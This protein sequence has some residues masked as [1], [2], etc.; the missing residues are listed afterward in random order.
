M[1]FITYIFSYIFLGK[2]RGTR[3]WPRKRWSSRKD[4]RKRRSANKRRK[5][6]RKRRKTNGET[7][8]FFIH[9]LLRDWRKLDLFWQF[10]TLF[11]HFFSRNTCK[12]NTYYLI[13][14]SQK[15]MP[16][17]RFWFIVK[18]NQNIRCDTFLPA[19]THF[20]PDNFCPHACILPHWPSHFAPV[21]QNF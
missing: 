2:K 10:W 3:K 6:W 14:I 15:Y 1:I 13:Q 11:L 16:E 12:C 5:N 20:A 17:N 18:N 21:L 8:E 9:Y 19:R 4:I 7:S